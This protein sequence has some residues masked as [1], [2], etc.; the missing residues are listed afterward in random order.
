MTSRVAALAASSA[1]G[2]I[3]GKTALL[4][5]WKNV[6]LLYTLIERQKALYDNNHS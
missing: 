4:S 6:L 1:V 5:P 3:A 2:L